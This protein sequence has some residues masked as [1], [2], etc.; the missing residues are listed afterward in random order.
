MYLL[1]AIVVLIG[2][3]VLLVPTSG[4]SLIAPFVLVNW[5]HVLASIHNRD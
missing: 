3:L 4:L 1:Y 5:M 2:S